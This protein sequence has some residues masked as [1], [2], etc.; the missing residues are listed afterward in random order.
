M[1]YTYAYRDSGGVRHEASMDAKCRE[2]V[3][4]ALRR[5][6]IR[7][8]KVVAADGS[9]ANGEV[10]GVRR[11]AVAAAVVA[12]AALAVGVTAAWFRLAAPEPDAAIAGDGTRRYPIGD[13]AVIEKGILTG[14][15]DVFADEG[16]RFL[17]SFAVPGVKAAVRNTTE[18]AVEAALARRVEASDGDGL[19]ARQ[20]KSIVEGMKREIRAYLAAGGTIEGYGLRLAERQ[21][22]ETAIYER[23]K[24]EV[25]RAKETLSADELI[26]FWEQ[27][28]AKLRRLGIRPI[29]LES[30]E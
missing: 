27:T 23:A 4:A 30:L 11:R 25:D 16:E 22:A 13:A 24:S 29:T 14:W 10:R 5:E 8:I 21:D 17:A 20:V 1:K 6:G 9:K 7:P 28:N 15:S 26:L 19:E 18:G 2:D 12:A 3:F